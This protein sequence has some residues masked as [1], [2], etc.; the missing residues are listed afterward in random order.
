[1]LKKI[2]SLAV[3]SFVLV[4]RVVFAAVEYD[5]HDIG[6]LQTKASQ[7]IALNNNGQILGWYNIDGSNTEKH[8]FVRNKDG[9]FYELPGKEPA[10]GLAINWLYLKD[11]GKAYGTFD[12]N[13]ATKA[14]CVWDQ[15]NGIVKLGV[16]PGKEISAINNAGQVLIKSVIEN[17]DGKSVCRP[18]IWENGKL[19]KLNGLEGNVG[20]LS[21]ESYGYDMNNKGEVVGQSLTYQVY[22]NEVYKQF[23]ATKWVNGQAIDL[24]KTVP[25]SAN[26]SAIALNDSGEMLMKGAMDSF[27]YILYFIGEGK[28]YLKG[29]NGSLKKITNSG[30]AYCECGAAHKNGNQVIAP[31]EITDKVKND[32]DSIWVKASEII[33]IN[34]KGEIIAQGETIYGEQ[35]AMLLTPVKPK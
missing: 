22:K 21:E 19:I 24:H 12:V 13:T 3:F 34:D 2:C 11:E 23:H 29:G 9:V 26:S 7:A 10:S 6:T 5:I 35:H 32:L 27:G 16:L 20:I 18:V 28:I 14:L 31:Y 4:S 1:M 17:I 30:C 25:K 33:S 8:F 15:R